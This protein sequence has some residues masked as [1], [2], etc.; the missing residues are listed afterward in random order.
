ML[1]NMD[2][3]HRINEALERQRLP[4][5][6]SKLRT[7][8]CEGGQCGHALVAVDTE[9]GSS[10]FELPV[11]VTTGGFSPRQQP[12]L[13]R[14]GFMV[15][16]EKIQPSVAERLRRSGTAFADV[17]G[18][19]F[20]REGQVVIDVRGRT[21]MPDRKKTANRS[22]RAVNLFAPKRAQVAALILSYPEVLSM[23]VRDIAKASGVSFGTTVNALNLFAETGYLVARGSELALAGHR[24]DAFAES[25]ADAFPAGLGKNIEIYRGFGDIH[26]LKE[27]FGGVWVSGE[28]AVPELVRGGESVQLYL[29]DPDD[30]ARI[31]RACRIRSSPEGTIT[32]RQAFWD[33]DVVQ[34]QA[35]VV[36]QKSASL[37]GRPQVPHALLYADLW[38]A[39]DPRLAEIAQEIRQRMN[40]RG[41]W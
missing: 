12:R 16:A 30:A 23:S 20:F 13:E 40:D 19:C 28:A 24:F 38:T 39:G 2:M 6:I 7:F 26:R 11:F 9:G 41:N 14:D 29:E 5:S 35:A 37:G 15:L 8:P 34:Q 18:N 36:S 33:L 1:L 17:R 31:I 4:L 22:T 27:E 21:E 25:W 10:T 3:R 32:L